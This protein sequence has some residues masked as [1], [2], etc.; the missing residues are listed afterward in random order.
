MQILIQH[1]WGGARSSAL[2]TPPRLMLLGL[3]LRS[4]KQGSIA[5]FLQENSAD[6][7]SSG[8]EHIGFSG[9]LV[10]SRGPWGSLRNSVVKKA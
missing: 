7:T 10:D 3:R 6:C 2:L 5:P 9:P 1:L 8:S 4:E